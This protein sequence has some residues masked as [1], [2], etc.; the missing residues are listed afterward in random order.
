MGFKYI[1]FLTLP[2]LLSASEG[3]E[4]GTDF[5]WR[6]FN[7]VI[8]A[9]ILYYLL[10]DKI[11]GFFSDRENSI[12]KELSTVQEKL[13]E[14]KAKKEEAQNSV[15]SADDKAKEI[16][17]I[18][19]K[20]AQIAKEKITRDLES[21][22]RNLEKSFN[23]RVEIETK[24]MKQEV[25]NEVISEIFTTEEGSAVSNEDLLNIIKKRVA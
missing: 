20:E 15:K 8:F 4:G 22:K 14:A 5:W 1:L 10:A 7:F 12:A 17:E 3:G 18:A 25:V 13:K 9:S 23:E 16:L 21:D 19:R 24:K 2:L 11:R 6:L